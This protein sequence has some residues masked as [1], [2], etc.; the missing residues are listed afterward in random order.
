MS[1]SL[2]V[3]EF[4]KKYPA[5][6]AYV[7][8]NR[9]YETGGNT[10]RDFFDYARRDEAIREVIESSEEAE[11]DEAEA[12]AKTLSLDSVTETEEDSGYLWSITYHLMN[13]GMSGDGKIGFFSDTPFVNRSV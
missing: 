12:E 5:I 10:F 8:R 2:T 11:L 1:L 7:F 3:P 6:T 9:F 4:E 13:L